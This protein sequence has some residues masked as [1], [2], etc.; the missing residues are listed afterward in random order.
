MMRFSVILT[1]LLAFCFLFATRSLNVNLMIEEMVAKRNV[2]RIQKDYIKADSIKEKLESDFNVVVIDYPKPSW[3]FKKKTIEPIDLMEYSKNTNINNKEIRN[4]K[5][6]LQDIL[7]YD[8][9]DKMGRK[10]ADISFNF[11]LSGVYDTELYDL[12]SKVTLKELMRYGDR[13]SC[14]LVDII[15]AIEKLS[16][17]GLKNEQFDCYK[18]LLERK[19]SSSKDKMS[20]SG[21][22]EDVRNSKFSLFSYYP[23]LTM[24]SHLSRQKKVNGTSASSCLDTTT[25]SDLFRFNNSLPIVIEL[26]SG[27]GVNLLKLQSQYK[28]LNYVGIDLNTQSIAYST[29][30][31]TRW[32]VTHQVKFVLGDVKEF[33]H[34]LIDFVRMPEYESRIDTILINF[35]TPFSVSIY[36][37]DVNATMPGNPQLPLNTED[38]MVSPVTL[39]LIQQIFVAQKAKSPSQRCNLYVQSNIEDVIVFIKNQVDKIGTFQY[40]RS[41]ADARILN[42]TQNICG[43]LFTSEEAPLNKRQLL[44]EQRVGGE[45]RALGYP[46][47]ASAPCNSV[48]ETEVHCVHMNKRIYRLLTYM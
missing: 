3:Q 33:L 22:I 36:D 43:D 12:L 8:I 16:I 13:K 27:F 45:T 14:R 38:F 7:N 21:T 20:V 19:S 17:S 48:S 24:F 44:V 46:Y 32:N 39:D 23:L 6:Y 9:V 25:I 10:Y 28:N 18:E 11:A 15:S 37:E 26:G 34:K 31:A 5:E 42:A 2:Y 35:P 4:V 47:L 41:Q 40:P 30:I 29:S 1:S